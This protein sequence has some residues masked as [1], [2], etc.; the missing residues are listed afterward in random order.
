[1]RKLLRVWLTVV[2][3]VAVAAC[4]TP[5]DQK[6]PAVEKSRVVTITAT[7]EALDLASRM[8]TLKGPEGNTITFRAD[9][10]VKNLPQVKVGDQVL[11]EYYESVAI[12][13]MKPGEVQAGTAGAAA[14]AKPGEKPGMVAAGET[15]ITASIEAIDREMSSVTL[16]GPEGNVE[17]VKVRDPKNLKNVKVGDQVVITYTVAVAISVEEVK[18]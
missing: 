18:K 6:K 2:C 8:V 17:T 5:T 7:V 4:A 3:A 14:T 11:A 13:V 15:T 9:D 1:M 16:K 10:R 12:Q